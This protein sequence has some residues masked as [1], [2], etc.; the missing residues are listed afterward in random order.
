LRVGWPR[1]SS[2]RSEAGYTYE[3]RCT[4]RVVNTAIAIIL[5][6]V[7]RQPDPPGLAVVEVMSKPK[8]FLRAYRIRIPV[9]RK[10]RDQ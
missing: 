4:D 9:Y 6:G 3:G 10:V 5:M 2:Q 7:S 1:E 8:S